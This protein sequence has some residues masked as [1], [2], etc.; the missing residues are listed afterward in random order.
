MKANTPPPELDAATIAPPSPALK[1]RILSESQTAWD[2]SD[3][4]SWQRPTLQLATYLAAACLVIVL[5]IQL[6]AAPS[7][8]APAAIAK[9]DHNDI[10][11][12]HPRIQ[13]K[14]RPSAA[15]MLAHIKIR[16]QMLEAKDDTKP[17]PKSPLQSCVSQQIPNMI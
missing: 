17:T 9:I 3:E 12:G 2:P 15:E 13:L 11:I 10:G 5:S 7:L 6:C 14:K 1:Q 4:I 8:D 16:N